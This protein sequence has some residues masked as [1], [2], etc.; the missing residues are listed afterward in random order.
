MSTTMTRT[1]II[2]A[3]S[4]SRSS[5]NPRNDDFGGIDE[6]GDRRL[7]QVLRCLD[8]IE[9]RAQL[10]HA[11]E[12]EVPMKTERSCWVSSKSIV[13]FCV[14]VL[15]WGLQCLDRWIDVVSIR[16][17]SVLRRSD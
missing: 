9:D 13:L 2:W 6:G 7:W 10:P 4:P 14:D 15:V 5:Y 3:E 12:F 1:A 8:L 16:D 17:M 11:T